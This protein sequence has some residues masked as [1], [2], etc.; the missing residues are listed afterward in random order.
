MTQLAVHL[1]VDELRGIVRDEVRSALGAKSE[2]DVLTR[3]QVAALL[4]V[5]PKTVSRLVQRKLLHGRWVGRMW[6]FQ[7]RDVQSYL[8][9]RK[10][11][12]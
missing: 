11:S 1:T 10:E 8:V 6:R 12:A 5:H 2:D 4:H 7:R 3:G 9:E